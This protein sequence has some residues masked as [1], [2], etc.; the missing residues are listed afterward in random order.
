MFRFLRRGGLNEEE[1]FDTV[2]YLR[3]VK[4]LFENLNF[5]FQ[6]WLLEAAADGK[7]LALDHDPDG[8]HAAV[9]LYRVGGEAAE[10]VQHEPAKA[11]IKYHEEFSLCLESR[12]AA[13][14]ALKE[15]ADYSTSRDPTDRVAEANRQLVESER[16]LTRANAALR[17]VEGRAGTP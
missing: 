7:K 17:E 1:R 2:E 10:F 11:A 15:A 9:Y 4:P 16:R 8:Q 12:A 6:S 13:A 3:E 14:A 5:E